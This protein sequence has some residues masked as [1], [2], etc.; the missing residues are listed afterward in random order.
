MIWV[1]R[2]MFRVLT[3]LERIVLFCFSDYFIAIN[4]GE[5][6]WAILI[7]VLPML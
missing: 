5:K 2:T 7:H 1:F 4:L 3:I 6:V